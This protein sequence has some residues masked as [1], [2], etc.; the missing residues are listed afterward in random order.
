MKKPDDLFG[1]V[2]AGGTKFVCAIGRGPTAILEKTIIPTTTPAET[3]SRV[4]DFFHAQ[5][6]KRGSV[7]AVG[8]GSFGP[9]NI[10]PESNGYGCIFTTP[11]PGWSGFDM[12]GEISRVV[13]APSV[14]ETDVNCALIA[15][16]AWGAGQGIDDLVYITVGTGIGAGVM[17]EGNIVHGALHP[18]VGHMCLPKLPQDAHFAGACTIHRDACV[19]GLASGPAIQARWGVPA[20]ELPMEHE[21]WRMIAYYLSLACYNVLLCVSPRRIVLGGGVMQQ[22]HLFPL[23]RQALRKHLNGYLD[24]VQDYRDMEK[25]IVPPHFRDDAGV[26]GA[27]AIAR[28][29]FQNHV[30]KKG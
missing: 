22:I 24:M 28:R 5:K 11:K 18:E 7:A 16:A 17:V 2:E 19:E 29:S 12:A 10:N 26:I 30:N 15:E 21:G 4:A 23:I 20:I 25:L 8:I 14:I 3:V 27:M 13:K 1:G 6:T 9:V